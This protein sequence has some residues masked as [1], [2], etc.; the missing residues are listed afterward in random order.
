[1]T[2]T[3]PLTLVDD[4]ERRRVEME[5]LDETLFVEAGAGTGK[6]HELVERVVNLVVHAGVRLSAIAAITF[7][8]AAAAELRDRIRE[9][10]EKRLAADPSAVEKAACERAMADIDQAA[11][12]TLHGFCLRILSAHPLD[13][14]LPPN[15]EIL[16]EVASQLAFE[17]R[18][19]RFV[20]DLFD[21][22]DTEELV[23]RAWA[24]DIEVDTAS[25][26]KASFK[27]VAAIFEDSW[28]RLDLLCASV[29][30]PLAAVDLRAVSHALSTM[31]QA[32]TTNIK[33]DD[34]LLD[35]ARE[36]E[37][38]VDEVLGEA[39]QLRQL[40]MLREHS[41]GW[42]SSGKGVGAK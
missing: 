40:R 27:D 6:T 24:L 4:D 11:I 41:S 1:M 39:D 5:G 23:L 20:D 34:K 8:E 36:V 22:P 17:N 42:K 35:R 33:A 31:R 3:S 29:P 38:S 12:S 15:V 2:A 9:A 37:T 13:V 30:A 18:W 25:K 21:D 32:M 19:S 14:D 7:T 16:D 28:D 10:V 26:Y